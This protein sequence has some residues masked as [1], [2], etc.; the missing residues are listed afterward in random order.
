MRYPIFP[1]GKYKGVLLDELPLTYVSYALQEFTLPD[2]L[3]SDLVSSLF[4]RLGI[5]SEARPEQQ[6][7][8]RVRRELAKRYH[9]DRGG[10]NQAMQAINEFY[11]L[12]TTPAA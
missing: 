7:C 5:K 9:P 4:D 8:A 10:S 1:F 11:D 12:L 6:M 3:R 2:E